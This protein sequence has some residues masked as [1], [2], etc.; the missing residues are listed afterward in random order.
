[1]KIFVVSDIHVDYISNR[2]WIKKLVNYNFSKDILIISGDISS[3]INLI[4]EVFVFLKKVF[5]EVFFVPGNHD[6]W[7][8]NQK[9]NTVIKKWNILNSVVRKTGVHMEAKDFDGFSIVPIMSWYDFS[10][11][12]PS[13]ELYTIWRDFIACNLK[14]YNQIQDL[15]QY[16]CELN[17]K[18][19]FNTN[20]RIISFSHFVPDTRL[21]PTNKLKNLSLLVPVMGSTYINQYIKRIESI[22]HIYGHVHIAENTTIE[23]VNYINNSFGYP[24]ETLFTLKKIMCIDEIA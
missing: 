14:N 10:F 6:L 3:K 15:N 12:M 18:M 19:I 2:M 8:E 13:K 11:G 17:E 24:I 5:H 16:C 7:L 20:N 22:K 4:E 1:M 9:I 21:L 23:G